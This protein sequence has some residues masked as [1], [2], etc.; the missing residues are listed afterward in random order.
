VPVSIIPLA[1]ETVALLVGRDADIAR[2]VIIGT[3]MIKLGSTISARPP[4]DGCNTSC[5]VEG[6]VSPWMVKDSGFSVSTTAV[7]RRE[8]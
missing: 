1:D 7:G 5:G 2:T 4:E 3:P 6:E 8:I